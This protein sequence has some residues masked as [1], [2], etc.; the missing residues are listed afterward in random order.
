ML[1]WLLQYILKTLCF[2]HEPCCERLAADANPVYYMTLHYVFGVQGAGMT[3]YSR[4]A[5][6]RAVMRSS[7]RGAAYLADL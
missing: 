1:S 4:R 3:P 5:D 2:W 7:L 6:G